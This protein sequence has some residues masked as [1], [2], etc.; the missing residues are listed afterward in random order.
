LFLVLKQFWG[1]FYVWFWV[2][3]FECGDLCNVVVLQT[4]IL[5]LVDLASLCCWIVVECTWKWACICSW[6][7]WILS[8]VDFASQCC[9]IVVHWFCGWACSWDIWI[10]SLLDFVGQCCWVVVVGCTWVLGMGTCK[11][12]NCRHLVWLFLISLI[13]KSSQCIAD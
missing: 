7:I 9:W 13:Q 2:R 6:D 4:W 12:Q 5:S 10:L 11:L 8:L 3:M 1:Q